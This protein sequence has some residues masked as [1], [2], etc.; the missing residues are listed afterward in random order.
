MHPASRERTGA[1]K[2]TEG[3]T[4]RVKQDSKTDRSGWE[5]CGKR[6]KGDVRQPISKRLSSPMRITSFR[7]RRMSGGEFGG[8]KG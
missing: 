6:R 7:L 5:M 3:V 1:E 8:D 2:G 4:T